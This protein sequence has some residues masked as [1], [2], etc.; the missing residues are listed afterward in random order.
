[1]AIFTRVEFLG[2][3]AGVLYEIHRAQSSSGELYGYRLVRRYLK[4]PDREAQVTGLHK[5]ARDARRTG[6]AIIEELRAA[7]NEGRVNRER[8]PS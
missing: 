8:Y 2:A 3:V 4:W 5:S 1:M 6:V 7:I